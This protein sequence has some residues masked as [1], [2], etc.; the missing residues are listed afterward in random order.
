MKKANPD[1]QRA[2]TRQQPLRAALLPVPSPN[3]HSRRSGP[4]MQPL[5]DPASPGGGV[6]QQLVQESP[7][8]RPT[9]RIREDRLHRGP[10][11]SPGELRVS[12]PWDQ[13]SLNASSSVSGRSFVRILRT[14]PGERVSPSW[15]ANNRRGYPLGD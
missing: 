11:P 14:I 9:T 4:P 12:R 15:N 10:L 6:P 8:T 2:E 3:G 7:E 13:S 5:R 1:P